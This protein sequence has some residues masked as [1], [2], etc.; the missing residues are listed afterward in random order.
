MQSRCI[1]NR[2]R[3]TLVQTDPNQ[4]TART[5]TTFVSGLKIVVNTNKTF[6][7]RDSS[8]GKSDASKT[9]LV[10]PNFTRTTYQVTYYFEKFF[11]A[12]QTQLLDSS[13]LHLAVHSRK[14]FR[15]GRNSEPK[16]VPGKFLC[17]CVRRRR[18]RRLR[19]SVR[20]AGSRIIR[21]GGAKG[22]RS[23]VTAG[24]RARGRRAQS[25]YKIGS[26]GMSIEYF[27]HGIVD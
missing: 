20:G 14:V 24:R 5:I 3:N 23:S 8:S 13:M 9:E 6:T 21:R 19:Q 1:F 2:S 4:T 16:S 17:K 18:R 12:S 26:H 27:R 10:R 25:G 7:K 15:S 22:F 11:Y